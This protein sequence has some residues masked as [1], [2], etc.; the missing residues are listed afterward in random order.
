[1]HARVKLGIATVLIVVVAVPLFLIWSSATENF[2]LSDMLEITE[3]APRYYGYG[4]NITDGDRSIGS[5]FIRGDYYL[6]ASTVPV[7]LQIA[8]QDWTEIDS[9]NI[10]FTPI[11]YS[12]M[13]LVEVPSTGKGVMF[14]PSEDKQKILFSM[15]DLGWAGK[16]SVRWIFKVHLDNPANPEAAM[17]NLSLSLS[18]HRQNTLQLTSL[19]VEAS[20]NQR[21]I[22][23]PAF[24]D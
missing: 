12:K 19:G 18:M 1:M 13:D 2:M 20:L 16:H 14:L 6:N 24:G 8:H 22:N 3:F 9:I 5:I 11:G 4:A 21:M 23:H 7:T 10:E 17:F 15:D